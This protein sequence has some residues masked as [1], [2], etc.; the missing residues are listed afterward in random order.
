MANDAIEKVNT[1]E[2]WDEFCDLLKKAGDVLRRSE[3]EAAAEALVAQAAPA[4]AD[5]VTLPGFRFSQRVLASV[6]EDHGLG[7]ADAL[8]RAAAALDGG[9]RYLNRA[10]LEAAAK[11][12]TDGVPELAAY[13]RYRR[14]VYAPRALIVADGRPLDFRSEEVGQQGDPCV[15]AD[16]AWATHGPNAELHATLKA[17]GGA[18]LFQVDDGY[19]LGP[20]DVVYRAAR[21]YGGDIAPLGEELRLDKSVA[22]CPALGAELAHHEHHESATV[23]PS[24][25]LVSGVPVGD[26]AFIQ[27]HLAAEEGRVGGDRRAGERRHG[28]LADDEG[29]EAMHRVR[30]LRGV[31]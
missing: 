27:A 20:P 31:V 2:A 15:C 4:A 26:P 8:L 10:E 19:A 16:Y 21:A 24:G 22:F 11:Q 9:N 18:A 29:V 25:I 30:H 17:A 23:A 1:A 6:L 14:L 28:G 12:L 5:E 7:D 3:L 13:A